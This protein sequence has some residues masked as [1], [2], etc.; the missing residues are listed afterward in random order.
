[1]SHLVQSDKTSSESPSEK[2]P[3]N[4]TISADETESAVEGTYT[5]TLDPTAVKRLNRKLDL[6]VLPPLF[7]LYFLSFLDR[8]N[9]GN[10]RIQG[11]EA[12][13]GMSGQQYSIALCIFFIPYVLFEV[14]SN[15]ILKRLSPSTW[16]SILVTSWGII[17][18][19]QG[20]VHNFGEIVALRFILGVFEAGVFP[21][22]MY[23]LAM[24]YPRYELQ[25]RFGMFF[26]SSTLAGAFG[27]LLAYAI[28]K[29]DGLGGLDGWR[30]IF[31]I[32]GM[33]TVTY[34]ICAK[35]LVVDW[36]D[37]AKFLKDDQKALQ[38]AKMMQDDGEAAMDRL[39]PAARKRIFLDWKIYIGCIMYIGTINTTY[40]VS[41]FVPTIIS[42]MGFTAS[43]AQLRTIPLY[44]V[45]VVIQLLFTYMA[46]RFR[47]RCFF[48]LISI[49]FGLVGY[50]I[51][52]ASSDLSVNVRYF[53][54]F[55]ITITGYTTLPLI[56]AWATNQLV[57]QYKRSIG[58]AMVV[59]GGNCGGLIAS[60]I[61][62]ESE[63]PDYK[64]GFSVCLALL[65][66]TALAAIGFAVGL[67]MENRAR[68]R[69]ERDYRLE[70][71]SEAD[72]LGDEHPRYRYA[73]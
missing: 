26:P 55:L 64:T 10:A 54:C 33:I 68:E 11:F 28:A 32:E 20:F 73:L 60:N 57:G 35:W 29:M 37:S 18:M 71:V 27:G 12:S 2:L 8:G 7:I 49:I 3:P 38:K 51:L 36:P 59:G 34:G 52:L 39:T 56:L 19:C 9:I 1:M 47:N 4:P 66:L 53:A 41:F 50:S 72:N 23:I 22:C 13:L 61:F 40:A 65:L 16:L 67:A 42:Q 17:T 21:G 70:D 25:W 6:H 43:D 62:F 44:A 48:T 69:G 45:A 58:V 15:L 14:P 5:T 31:I 24:Y 63:S 30:W 46:D